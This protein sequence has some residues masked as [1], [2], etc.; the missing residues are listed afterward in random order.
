MSRAVR[1]EVRK[2]W[3]TKLWWGMLIGSVAFAAV[4]VI[5]QIAMSGGGGNPVPPLTFGATQRSIFASAA[6]GDIFALIVGVILVTTEYRHFTSRPTFLLEP[7]RWRVIVAKLVVA[8]GVGMLYG[9]V[10]VVV[11][12]AII[13]PWFAVDG[14]T[15]GWLDNG[16]ILVTLGVLLVVSVFAVLGI[17]VGVLIRNQVA[18]V[19]GALVYLFVVEPLLAVI[20]GVSD[21]ARFLPEASAD[22]L[23]GFTRNGVQLLSPWE[24]GLVLLGWGLLFALLGGILTVRQDIP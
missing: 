21:I 23:I 18:A 8:A 2:V 5:S 1:A 22:A 11:S 16:L 3:T 6:G 15:I 14:V 4:G 12:I 13:V 9:V 24:G 20:P 7:R 10:G 19:I 17:G